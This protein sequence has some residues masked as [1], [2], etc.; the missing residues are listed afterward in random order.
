MTGCQE[1]RTVGSSAI[2]GIAQE[3]F[4]VMERLSHEQAL[5]IIGFVYEPLVYVSHNSNTFS[6]SGWMPRPNTMG[7]GFGVTCT[8]AAGNA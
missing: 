5:L 7:F 4:R 8:R 3:V 1:L 6:P 2:D